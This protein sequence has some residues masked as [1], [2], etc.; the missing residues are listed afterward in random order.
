MSEE[1][2]V[3]RKWREETIHYREVSFG[4][5]W[6]VFHYDHPTALRVGECIVA[7][8]MFG[9]HDLRKIVMSYYGYLAAVIDNRWISGAMF[10]R[11]RWYGTHPERDT[12]FQRG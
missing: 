7:M 2:R 5:M 12:W 9:I 1:T 3:K 8:D 4:E 10:Y 11:L 6:T